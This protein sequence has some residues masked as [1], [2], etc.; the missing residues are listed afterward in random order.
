MNTSITLHQGMTHQQVQQTLEARWPLLTIVLFQPSPGFYK[1]DRFDEEAYV[2]PDYV[3]SKMGRSTD[4]IQIQGD[5]A[6]STVRRLLYETYGLESIIAY[7]Y[8]PYGRHVPGTTL[9][10]QQ[11]TMRSW[12]EAFIETHQRSPTIDDQFIPY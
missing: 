8:N 10:Q 5:M 1:A 3:L 4:P 2:A 9:D 6:E 12:W 7:R 11:E